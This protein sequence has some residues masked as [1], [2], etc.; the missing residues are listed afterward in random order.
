MN[1]DVDRSLRRLKPEKHTDRLAA[2][3]H[4]DLNFVAL[5]APIPNKLMLDTT[6]YIDALQG[7]LRPEV[8]IVLRAA[9][10]WHSSV[11]EA[12]LSVACG[13]LDPRHPDTPKAIGQIRASL[14]RRPDHR[15]LT[16]D[17][18]VWREAGLAC[19]IIARLQGYAKIERRKCLNDSLIFFTALKQG[20][21]VLTRS[22]A[23]FDF[24]MQLVPAGRTLFYR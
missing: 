19:G 7:R 3:D 24:L 10:I 20:C 6:V 17:R 1:S 9:G 22:I 13:A 8:E 2:R 5:S 15:I 11:T 18:Q 14:E 16:P 23:D 21:T 12:E 4:A